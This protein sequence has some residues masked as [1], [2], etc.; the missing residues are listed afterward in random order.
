LH[1]NPD[2]RVYPMNAFRRMVTADYNARVF[3]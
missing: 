3:V 2:A 1:C